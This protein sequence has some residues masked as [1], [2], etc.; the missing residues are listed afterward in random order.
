MSKYTIMLD[1]KTVHDDLDI[2]TAI[3]VANQIGMEAEEV[4]V[5]DENHTT[6]WTTLQDV[7]VFPIDE[8]AKRMDEELD[9]GMEEDPEELLSLDDVDEKYLSNYNV[10]FQDTSMCA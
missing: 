10:T 2:L 9:L 8:I 3:D 5:L 4:K 7:P 1:G 6:V